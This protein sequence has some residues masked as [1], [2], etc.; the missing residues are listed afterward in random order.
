ML[1]IIPDRQMEI[2]KDKST[3]K[4]HVH[5]VA[6]CGSVWVCP[7]CASKIS[8]ARR[9][10]VQEALEL[11]EQMDWK[12]LFVTLTASH[13]REDQLID[14]FQGFKSAKRYM[15]SGRK[16]QA[17][18]QDYLVK[19]SITATEMTWGFANGW[20]V[21]FHEIFFIGAAAEVSEV[22]ERFYQLWSRSLDRERL[23][24]D[25]EHGV[26]VQIG[27]ER[28]GEYITKWGLDH[29]LTSLGK[30][31]KQG[32]F[33]PFQL[34]ALYDQG[35]AWAG[36]LFQCYADVTK[37]KVS[38]RWSN[39]LRDKI[40]LS[41]ELTDQEISEAEAGEDSVLL[42][43]LTNKQYRKI[44]YSGRVG[45]LGEMLSVSEAGQEALRIWLAELFSIHPEHPP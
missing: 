31:A 19:G 13:T 34:L 44:L 10:E 23:S 20:H 7:V 4:T 26:K 5:G 38:L 1:P 8:L 2:W 37:G 14:L 32:S 45:V 21:H 25:R 22:E 17:V 42:V 16:W 18:K 35:E 3:G 24:C 6:R 40:G 12:V 27:S 39:G 9:E 11:A 36:G 43:T 29:E 28:A 33:N 15:R 30:D 41:E